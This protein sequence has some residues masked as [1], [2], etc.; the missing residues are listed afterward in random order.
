VN[1]NFNAT[2]LP[3]QILLTENLK[4]PS[5]EDPDPFSFHLQEQ[6]RLAPSHILSATPANRLIHSSTQNFR[7]VG[8]V[9]TV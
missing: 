2:V 8:R 4:P 6:N 3:R 7:I 5:L 9:L 1:I